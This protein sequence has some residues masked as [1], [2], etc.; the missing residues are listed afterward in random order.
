MVATQILA[1]V[2]AGRLQ[3]AVEGLVKGAYAITL[4]YSRG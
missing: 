2:E 1:T 4:A 3:K